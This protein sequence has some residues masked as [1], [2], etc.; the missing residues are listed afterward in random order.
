MSSGHAADIM[1]PIARDERSAMIPTTQGMKTPPK[2]PNVERNPNIEAPPRGYLSAV[3]P[4]RHGQRQL[5]ASPA[6]M[7][8]VRATLGHHGEHAIRK[9]T[10][11]LQQHASMIL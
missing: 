9:N 10:T 1:R 6:K 3:T 8:A 2:F 4:S 11:E 5:P 7:Q